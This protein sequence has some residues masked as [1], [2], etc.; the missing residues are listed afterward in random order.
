MGAKHLFL[1]IKLSRYLQTEVKLV[2][3]SYIRRNGFF[4]HCENVLLAMMADE[5][6]ENRI[7][8]L[9]LIKN[10]R[11]E[12]ETDIRRFEVPKMNFDASDY[13]KMIEWDVV[14]EPPIV[15][16]I[17]IEELENFIMTN[18]YLLKQILNFPCHTQAVE[19]HVQEVTKAAAAQ[20]DPKDQDARVKSRLQF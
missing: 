17:P 5:N 19:R 20:Y 9:R 2:I 8:A 13:T 16:N 4:A 15:R 3:D 12:P 7:E 10:C 14:T 6:I 11:L 1:T 18:F